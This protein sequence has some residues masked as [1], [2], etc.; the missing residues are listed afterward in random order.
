MTSPSW[1][2]VDNHTHSS[3]ISIN[4]VITGKVLITPILFGVDTPVNEVVVEIMQCAVSISVREY[5]DANGNNC[6][7]KPFEA[8][9]LIGKYMEFVFDK[10]VYF[11]VGP[12]THC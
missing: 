5:C 1:I 12:I 9:V 4:L 10:D 6:K 8:S 3:R 11:N 2:Y 7:P